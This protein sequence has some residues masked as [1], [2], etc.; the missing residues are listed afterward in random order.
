MTSLVETITN[1]D[2]LKAQS[3]FTEKM[4]VAFSILNEEKKKMIASTL[5]EEEDKIG[6]AHV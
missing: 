5:T 4:L 3:I 2:F 1:K 6:R